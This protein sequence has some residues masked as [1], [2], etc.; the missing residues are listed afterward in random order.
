MQLLIISS[1][2]EVFFIQDKMFTSV[3]CYGDKGETMNP[4]TVEQCRLC[5]RISTQ[6]YILK[7]EFIG[8]GQQKIT[9]KKS[10]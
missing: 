4:I 2:N 10:D 5:R 8:F 6:N 1:L 3:T 7:L 9:N